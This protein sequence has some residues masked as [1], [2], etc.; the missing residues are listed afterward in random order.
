MSKSLKNNLIGLG[1]GL[2]LALAYIFV[3]SHCFDFVYASN[4]DVLLKA[5]ANG[6]ITGFPDGH[7]IYIMYPL[8]GFLAFL[9]NL[10][11]NVAWFDIMLNV[12][13][14]LS[15]ILIITKAANLR[16]KISD[17]LIVGIS[18][19]LLFAAVDMSNAVMVQYS[20]VSALLA[21]TALFYLASFNDDYASEKILYIS[22]VSVI[23]ITL[24][25]SMLL[26]KEVM[27]LA[28]PLGIMIVAVRIAQM[29]RDKDNDHK[30]NIKA[31][32]VSFLAGILLFAI[33]VLIHIGAY[34]SSEWREF[35]KYNS[36]RTDIFDYYEF[37]NINLAAYENELN[38]AGIE[39]GDY[40]ALG[41][42]NIALMDNL[43]LNIISELRDIAKR[44]YDQRRQNYSVIKETIYGVAKEF[45]QPKAY[46][47]TLLLAIVM[48]LSIILLSYHRKEA[49]FKIAVLSII[50][51]LFVMA[52][53]IYVGRWPQ[54]VS[55]GLY[56]M[57]MMTLLGVVLRFVPSSSGKM[58]RYDIAVYAMEL[59]GL[60]FIIGFSYRDTVINQKEITADI[61]K[62]QCVNDYCNLNNNNIYYVE[63]TSI[64]TFK[65]Y[66]GN[67]DV[68]EANNVIRLGVWTYGGPLFRDYLG[69]RGLDDVHEDIYRDNVYVITDG[70]LNED[71]LN[72]VYPEAKVEICDTIMMPDGSSWNVFDVRE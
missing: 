60:M 66:S 10:N 12:F 47:V 11:P 9:Y 13:R 67:A 31:G 41:R 72:G 26:R 22:D 58:S 3:L 30:K 17:K 34:S 56:F 18:F 44:D 7:L 63:T 45:I 49:A 21:G 5:I 19:I 38:E 42:Y 61:A 55:F 64:R 53:F 68:M 59:I 48:V 20:V 62:W 16:N 15:Y 14:V 33:C 1:I 4:D 69:S 37:E 54:R 65:E 70:S 50:Y 43:D 28:M 46:P 57:I 6:S 8:G 32:W 2:G 71:F 40:H 29:H 39:S 25:L 51:M 52:Y 35:N 24:I 23:I 36:L 27:A